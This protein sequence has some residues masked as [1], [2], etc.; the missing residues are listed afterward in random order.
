[1]KTPWESELAQFLNDLSAVQD[2]TL[3]VLVK[4]R[5]FLVASDTEGLASVNRQEESLLERLQECLKRREEL[6]GRAAQEGLPATN[7]DTLSRALPR[8]ERTSLSERMQSARSK[9]R[10]LQHHS[11]VN[12]MLVQRT[13]LHLSQVLEIIATGGRLQPTYGRRGPVETSGSLVD[14][15]V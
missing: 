4:K 14:G 13:L 10:L 5:E 7:L 3:G 2:E 6:L 8:S 9:T 12:W 15:A 11:L 1:M